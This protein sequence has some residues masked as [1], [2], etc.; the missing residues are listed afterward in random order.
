MTKKNMKSVVKTEK[1]DRS[2]INTFDF[3][4]GKLILE[5]TTISA[6]AKKLK[7]N[8]G[9]IC[10]VLQGTRHRV[11]RYRFV[12]VNKYAHDHTHKNI[13]ISSLQHAAM[14]CENELLDSN[15]NAGI[16]LLHHAAI[17]CENEPENTRNAPF[18]VRHFGSKET[19]GKFTSKQK[20]IDAV[21]SLT[22]EKLNPG[23]IYQC[24]N[25][26]RNKTGVYEFKYVQN[27]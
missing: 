4:N 8:S 14:Y 24:L 26:T 20:A 19:V 1:V 11:K 18:I 5:G 25:G 22:G 16:T 23:S 27:E 21:E 15:V 2:C 12:D 3:N 10:R 9:S 13:G 6:T 7:I 17:K